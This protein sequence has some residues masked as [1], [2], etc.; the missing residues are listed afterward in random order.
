M[1]LAGQA[2]QLREAA[3]QSLESGDFGRAHELA[4][5]AQQIQFTLSG[6]SLRLLSAWLSATTG[7]E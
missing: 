2:W 3:R 7:Q 1:L 4:L 6:D 5:A